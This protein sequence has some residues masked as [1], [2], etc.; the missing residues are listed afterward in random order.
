MEQTITEWISNYGVLAIF[1]LMILNGSL[2]APPSEIILA[3]AGI[4]AAKGVV[5]ISHALIS[6]VLG[7]WIG[8]SILYFLGRKFGEQA[9][10]AV[11]Q[12]FVNLPFGLSLFS[13]MLPTKGTIRRYAKR[14]HTSFPWWLFYCRCFPV[15][16][17]MISIPAGVSRISYGVFSTL[18]VLGALT[19][20]G[21]WM[22][23][24]FLT[25]S[26]GSVGKLTAYISLTLFG[27]LVLFMLKVFHR[28]MSNKRI[29]N[30]N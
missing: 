8:T 28:Y 24:G 7:N 6:A 30:D 2:S 5:P 16:R 9:I 17:S 26:Q 4:F 23:L 19:W 29:E 27:C 13:S 22:V 11:R 12:K 3:C 18:T 20:A 10:V 1:V 25:E 14:H 21:A 15:I